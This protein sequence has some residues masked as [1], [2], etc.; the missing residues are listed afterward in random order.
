[1]PL[2]IRSALTPAERESVSPVIGQLLDGVLFMCGQRRHPHPGGEGW[3]EGEL[4][5]RRRGSGSEIPWAGMRQVFGLHPL[6]GH[7]G[8]DYRSA[9]L[10]LDR[11]SRHPGLSHVSRAT[12]LEDVRETVGLGTSETATRLW[13]L[14]VLWMLAVGTW[15]FDASR[16]CSWCPNHCPC[17]S[18]F[19]SRART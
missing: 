9:H 4:S 19:Q 7:F 13:G 2:K 15:N 14:D 1:M 16:L 8:L 18:S 5:M 10:G 3:G 11:R 6:G 17:C 12:G